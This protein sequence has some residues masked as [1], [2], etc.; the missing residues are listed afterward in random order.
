MLLYHNIINTQIVFKYVCHN[1]FDT[2]V[3]ADMVLWDLLCDA[4]VNEE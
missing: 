1:M 3:E 4:S 2:I